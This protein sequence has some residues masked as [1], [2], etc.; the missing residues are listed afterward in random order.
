MK[1]WIKV[2]SGVALIALL[3]LSVMSI[4][5]LAHDVKNEQ[6]DVNEKTTDISEEIEDFKQIHNWKGLPISVDNSLLSEK[7]YRIDD[8][9]DLCLPVFSN[10][11]K[12]IQPMLQYAIPKI[13][14]NNFVSC[15]GNQEDFSLR[16]SEKHSL[17]AELY[18][19]S[20]D[21]S[22]PYKFVIEATSDGSFH[23]APMHGA[24][25]SII[26]DHFL[27]ND[28]DE[29]KSSF[30]NFVD[31]NVCNFRDLPFGKTWMECLHGVG[32]GLVE[33]FPIED[34][35]DYCTKGDDYDWSYSCASGVFMEYPGIG[36]TSY[37]PCDQLPY[38]PMCFMLKRSFF[39]LIQKK[40]I[41]APCS[42]YAIAQDDKV[43][44]SCVW[45]EGT[46]Q[47]SK[48]FLE[49]DDNCKNYLPFDESLYFACMDGFFSTVNFKSNDECAV[50]DN[51]TVYDLC[52]YYLNRGE[53]FIATDQFY[54]NTPLLEENKIVV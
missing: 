16:G 50:F 19:Y 42:T 54:F 32:H 35:L 40:N 49:V 14:Y 22:L 12:N 31:E 28:N 11:T 47:N 18:K 15:L 23:Y 24:I 7:R 6:I 45:G 53:Y 29:S 17:G 8:I 5:F 44:K 41:T 33:S 37:H 25:W 30:S 2:L 21:Q 46:N 34:A 27:F 36:T 13:G 20:K 43:F 10:F 48:I 39:S 38:S 3:T 52:E 9:K 51:D 4:S 26:D 1:V